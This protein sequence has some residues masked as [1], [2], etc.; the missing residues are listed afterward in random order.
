MSGSGSESFEQEEIIDKFLN[1]DIILPDQQPKSF[2]ITGE[3]LLLR[4]VFYSAIYDLCSKNN[5]IR[6]EA[7]AWFTEPGY[8]SVTLEMGLSAIGIDDPEEL[9]SIVKK[10]VDK[11]SLVLTRKNRRLKLRVRKEK[12]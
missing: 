4:E 7:Y 12:P 3:V 8:G 5:R 10:F 1:P 6:R 2:K 9:R 11:S